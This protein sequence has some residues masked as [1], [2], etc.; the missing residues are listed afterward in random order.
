MNIKLLSEITIRRFKQEGRRLA[1]LSMIVIGVKGLV[2]KQV[3]GKLLLIIMDKSWQQDI[4]K[5]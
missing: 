1:H 4:R 2:R 5:L 3:G